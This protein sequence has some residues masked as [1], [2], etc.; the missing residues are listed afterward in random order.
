MAE[1]RAPI[2]LIAGDRGVRIRKGPDPLL[3]AVFHRAGVRR[4]AVAYIGAASGD[5]AAFRL[6]I[7]KRLQKAGAGKV[8]LAPLYGRHGDTEKAKVV[9]ESSD[10]VFISGGDVEEG[11]RVLQEKKIIETLRRLYRSGKPFFG[12]SAGS[13]MLALR[14]IRWTEPDDDSTSELFDC[15]GFASVLCDT[16]GESEGWEELQ[17]LL[18]LSPTGTVGHGI[19]SGAAVVV[20]PD[21]TVSA[22]GGEVHRFRK[23]ARGVT[24]IENLL[25]A[26]IP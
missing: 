25:P 5:N 26:E 7:T 4:P 3:Q 1:I 8:S 11:M 14:W 12:I 21:G 6:M 18:A 17:A 22:L 23:E 9:L 24:R 13:I 10:L 19:V 2:F 16:H 15:L 20:E